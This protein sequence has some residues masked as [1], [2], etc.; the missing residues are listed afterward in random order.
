MI[1]HVRYFLKSALIGIAFMTLSGLAQAD[2]PNKPI[3]LVSPYGPGGLADLAARSLASNVTSFIDKPV[4]VVNRAGAAGV[5]G[6]T[7][8]AK[9]SPDGYTLLLAR[10]G[11]QAAV[12]AI[13]KR[14]PY[15]WDEFTFL[16]LLELNNFALVV[17]EKSKYKT[18]Q[19]LVSAIKSGEKLSYASTGVGTLLHFG[20][21]M[22]L[23][24]IGVSADSLK[25]IPY[26]GGGNAMAA[27][28]GGHV[29]MMFQGLS[30][31]MGGIESGQLR[32]LA[33]TSPKR[34]P[35]VKSVPTVAEL[36]Y[37][38]LEAVVGWSALYGPPNLPKPVVDKWVAVLE[39]LKTDPSWIEA[40]KKLGS[41]PDI[42]SPA[43]TKVFVGKQ[44]EEFKKLVDK[45][46]LAI[47]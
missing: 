44:Y 47:N 39:K 10:V 33:V 32:A 2:Y 16:G 5:T 46:N 24:E 35:I 12:P 20:M 13:N 36:G 14:T 34:D 42:K 29:D 43:N 30:G 15:K 6:S 45:L 22:M 40:T 4:V 27:V 31:V 21:L 37:P 7:F 41:I 25:H 17:N 28:S 11:S 1:N 3:T 19:E 18:F 26:K 38:G 23:N 8:V 9:S